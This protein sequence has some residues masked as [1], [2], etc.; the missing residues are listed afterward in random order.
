M[1]LDLGLRK[2]KEYHTLPENLNDY[3][4]QTLSPAL[5]KW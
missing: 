3:N 5:S 1:G 4:T 2:E